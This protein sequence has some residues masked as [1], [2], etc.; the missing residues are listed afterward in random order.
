MDE[1]EVKYRLSGAD[2]HERLRR[3]LTE[4]GAERRKA[5]H[6][7]NRLFDDVVRSLAAGGAVLRVRTLDGGPRA[8]LTFKGPASF[9][10]VV[11]RR[12]EIETG[13]DDGA[14]LEAI[15]RAVGLNPVIE[16]EKDR[17]TWQLEGVEVALDTLAFGHF[18]EIEGDAEAIRRIAARLALDESQ[19]EPAGYPTLTEKW[20]IA[21]SE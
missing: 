17:E 3:L 1:V 21:N 14:A 11:K 10:G 13:V 8:R 15:L 2:A 4:I 16:Y 20:R 9:D 6:E 19:A 12:E 7:L 5:E 18:C